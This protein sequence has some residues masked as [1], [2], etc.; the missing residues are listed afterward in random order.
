MEIILLQDA[1]HLGNDLFPLPF[2]DVLVRRQDAA[3][4]LCLD[5]AFDQFQLTEFPGR[6]EGDGHASIAGAARPA[7]AVDVAF[8]ILGHIEIDHVGDIVD[9]EA[10]G[11]HIG[12]D[13]D[14]H[15]VLAELLH[16]AVTLALAQIA[17]QPLCLVAPRGKGDDELIHTLFG[18]AEDDHLEII[19]RIE[20]AAETVHL[21]PGL[22]VVL[23]NGRRRDDFLV[24]GHKLRCPHIFLADAQDGPGHR[25]GKEHRLAVHRDLFDD[26]LDILDKAHIEHFIR[27]VKDEELNMVQFDRPSVQ[28]V[29]EAS[30]RADHDLDTAAQVA[31]L[32][33]D[34]LTAVDR[35]Y[36]DPFGP[37]DLADLFGDL[38][39]QFPRRGHD[40]RLYMAVF[41]IQGLDDG[42][43]EGCGFTRARL[44][45]PDDVLPCKGQ[46]D[47]ALLDR[48]RFFEPHI[49][50]GRQN[51]IFNV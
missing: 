46:R 7:D 51:F 26:R 37:S 23:G 34:R 25:R 3:D 40:K 48:G 49:F 32:A 28:M 24:D 14:I 47:G 4:D 8:R 5:G 38:D 2:Q 13:K 27:F 16:Y 11:R 42:N 6:D 41:F 20:D 45:L 31:D 10:A 18:A 35:Q 39:A 36:T 9:I 19:R 22:I 15:L 21:V 29:Q 44:G 1:L 43:A 33:L 12:G 50:Q 30:R 17:V